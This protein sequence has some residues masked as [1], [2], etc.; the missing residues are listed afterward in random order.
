MSEKDRG[1]PAMVTLSDSQFQEARRLFMTYLQVTA[2]GAIRSLSEEEIERN[3]WLLN[4]AGFSQ[5][6]IGTILQA[7]QSTI[8]RILAGKPTK[9]KGK[10]GG[11]S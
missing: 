4:A 10:E 2:L 7:S 11:E 8:S 6:K 1:P 5:E 3:A 9:R